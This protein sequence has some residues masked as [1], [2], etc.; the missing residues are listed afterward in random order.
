MLIF[1]IYALLIGFI[2]MEKTYCKLTINQFKELIDALPEVRGQIK[3]LPELVREAPRER[4]DALLGSNFCWSDLYEL[5]LDESLAFLFVAGGWQHILR[6]FVGSSDPQQAAIQWMKEGEPLR[7]DEGPS[8][9]FEEKYIIGAFVALQRNILSIML[10][11]RSICD[12]V[13]QVRDSSEWREPFFKAVRVDRSVLSCPTFASR[14]ARAELERDRYFFDSLRSALKGPQKKHW[15]AYQDLRYALCVLHELGFSSM[16]DASLEDLLV[17]QLK[18]YPNI[19]S[20]RKN[21]RKQFTES[22]RVQL[23]KKAI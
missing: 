11:H 5:S 1:N 16:S 20:A 4:I 19:P 17:H 12:L 21:L 7:V 9:A 6:E 18:V 8:N 22:K 14:L 2:L 15:E 3:Q 13:R 23:P 10:Y